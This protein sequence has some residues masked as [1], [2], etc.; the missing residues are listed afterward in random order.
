M[1]S[2]GVF[3]KGQIHIKATLISDE[4]KSVMVVIEDNQKISLLT[5]RIA[6]KLE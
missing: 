2:E 3:N 1:N 5:K 6:V 4:E